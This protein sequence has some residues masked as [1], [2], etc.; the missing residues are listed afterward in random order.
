M[1]RVEMPKKR[2]HLVVCLQLHVENQILIVKEQNQMM[3]WSE[4]R[5]QYWNEDEEVD[6]IINPSIYFISLSI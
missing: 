6:V 1:K 3:C 5:W 2:M 4:A